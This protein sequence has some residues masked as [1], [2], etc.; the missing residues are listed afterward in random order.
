MTDGRNLGD[1]CIEA[2][3]G[4]L[5]N[6]CRPDV[7]AEAIDLRQRENCGTTRM[8]DGDAFWCAC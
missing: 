6:E 2:R 8:V 4:E 7:M 3:R 5:Q 1:R